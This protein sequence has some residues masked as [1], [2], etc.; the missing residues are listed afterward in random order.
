MLDYVSGS[1]PQPEVPENLS[2]HKCPYAEPAKNLKKGSKGDGVRWIQWMLEECGYS[3]GKYGI[4]GDFGG[5]T[6]SA[7]RKL[8]KD[9]GLVVDA[10]VGPLT[11]AALKAA[12]E[13]KE[14]AR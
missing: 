6:R 2:G 11:R 3:V 5:D 9:S 12:Y 14:A 10:I 8:Q 7:V 4:D 1:S 13:Q